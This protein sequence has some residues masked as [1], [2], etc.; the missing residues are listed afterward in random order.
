MI[1]FSLPYSIHCSVPYSLC[2]L[3]FLFL[4]TT[5]IKSKYIKQKAQI[6][7][8][9]QRK[10]EGVHFFLLTKN[11]FGGGPVG[12]VWQLQEAARRMSPSFFLLN[13]LEH[14]ASTLRVVSWWQMVVAA[15]AIM[16]TFY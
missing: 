14:L 7:V 9:L 12:A 2:F 16:V 6:P 3:L 8:T 1:S 11:E 13:H 15:L 4:I 5:R 10:W